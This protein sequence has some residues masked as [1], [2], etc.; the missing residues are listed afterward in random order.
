MPLTRYSKETKQNKH[1]HRIYAST[2]GPILHYSLTTHQFVP[3]RESSRV[4]RV[5]HRGHLCVHATWWAFR[6]CVDPERNEHKLLI[7]RTGPNIRCEFFIVLPTLVL[8]S[9]IEL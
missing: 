4:D 6:S 5:Q 3:F 8:I 2:Y 9:P 1:A 7:G